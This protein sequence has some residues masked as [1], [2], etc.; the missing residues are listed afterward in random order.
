[1]DVAR[2][3]AQRLV[4]DARTSVFVHTAAPAEALAGAV[5]WLR[6]QG[7]RREIAVIS[8]FQAGTIDEADLRAIPREIGIE[9]I[10][11][12]LATERAP[13]AAATRQDSAAV[14][15]NITVD[16]VSTQVE[17]TSDDSV[18]GPILDAIVSSAADDEMGR[19]NAARRAAML[20]T[21]TL[22]ADGRHP[23]MLVHREYASRAEV[24]RATA[25]LKAAWQGDVVAR[26]RADPMLAGAAAMVADEDLAVRADSMTAPMPSGA[27]L[28]VLARTP[29][30]R[31]IA[32]A[33]AHDLRGI[34][35][36]VL[37]SETDAGSL[38]SAALIAATLRAT[39]RPIM[40][41]ELEPSVVS[42]P[43]LE[44]WRRPTA[45]MPTSAGADIDA[46]H[47]R[48][49]WLLALLLLGVEAWMRRVRR[50]AV[51]PAIAREQAA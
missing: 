20:S 14:T 21:A 11:V 44:G 4:A 45:A 28:V 6:T 34:D 24:L 39:A 23:I 31:P 42:E 46:S 1:M 15:A 17:W 12:D 27:P 32:F 7:G 10:R 9:L 26:L 18:A 3:E 30:G 47:G 48:W 50:D 8:D 29:S 41:E 2:A 33:G 38:A 19:A 40:A 36:L 35:W 16:S 13:L 22:V 51:G 49:L 5:G 37:F 43:T 25:P